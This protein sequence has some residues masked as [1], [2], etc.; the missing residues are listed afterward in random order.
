MRDDDGDDDDNDDDYDD[1]DIHERFPVRCVFL[2][3][4]LD[5]A[6]HGAAYA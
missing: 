4:F 6:F 3:R 2:L 1:E 5:V